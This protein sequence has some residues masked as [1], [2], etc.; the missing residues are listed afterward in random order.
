VTAVPEAGR[1]A[2][3]GGHE[4]GE[5]RRARIIQ[6]QVIALAD[7]WFIVIERGRPR[8]DGAQALDNSLDGETDPVRA[9]HLI[10]AQ[11]KRAGTTLNRTGLPKETLQLAG[12]AMRCQYVPPVLRDLDKRTPT[13][14]RPCRRDISELNECLEWLLVHLDGDERGVVMAMGMMGWGGRRMAR[15]DSRKR[16]KDTFRRIFERGVTEILSRL[17]A[18][19]ATS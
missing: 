4:F 6:G 16:S 14:V 13:T 18:G 7:G 9:R 1:K 10:K 12:A 17:L 19:Y 5:Y 2:A 8:D 15:I 3:V 11:L